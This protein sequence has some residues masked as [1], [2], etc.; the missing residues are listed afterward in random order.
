MYIIIVLYDSVYKPMPLGIFSESVCA[1][2]GTS[3]S[4][5]PV[6]AVSLAPQLYVCYDN[7]LIR[8][9]SSGSCPLFNRTLPVRA[10]VWLG[11]AD[12]FSLAL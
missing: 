11:H 10:C 9:L 7:Q 5:N 4:L 8:S 3:T 12:N 1:G 6:L 2:R